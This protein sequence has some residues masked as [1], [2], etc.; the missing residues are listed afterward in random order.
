MTNAN[1]LIPVLGSQQPCAS[2][3]SGIIDGALPETGIVEPGQSQDFAGFFLFPIAV[4][5]LLAQEQEPA[6]SE[7]VAPIEHRNGFRDL[8]FNSVGI[9][10]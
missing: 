1:N 10:W 4:A 9:G 5:S 7:R 8:R 3:D 6:H 2:C